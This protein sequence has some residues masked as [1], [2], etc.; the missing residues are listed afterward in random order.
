MI[1]KHSAVKIYP[2]IEN[3][4]WNLK[5]F[6]DSDWAGDPETRISVTG[7]I[8]YLLNVPVC[9][10]SKAQKGVTLSSSE[11][12]YV[13]I[14]EATKEIKFIFYLLRDIG[15]EVELPIIV[16]TDNIGAIFMSRKRIDWRTDSSCRHALSFYSRKYR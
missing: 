5:V 10:R 11:A 6:C 2:K 15:I 8:V 14:S 4:N 7:F 16:K 9:W 13:A 3:K 1:Q 12:E